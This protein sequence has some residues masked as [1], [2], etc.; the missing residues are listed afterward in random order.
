MQSLTER[1]KFVIKLEKL[2]AVF[3][4]SYQM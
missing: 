2:A 1:V 3:A 4:N